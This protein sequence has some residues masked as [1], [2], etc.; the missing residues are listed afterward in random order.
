VASASCVIDDGGRP[1]SLGRFEDDVT[2]ILCGDQARSCCSMYGAGY[3]GGECGQLVT[4]L[5]E[6]IATGGATYNPSAAEACLAVLRDQVRR[7]NVDM[8]VFGFPD[9]SPVGTSPCGVFV[10]G[11]IPVGQACS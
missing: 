2:S 7:C 9:P 6:V 11:R 10:A 5:L 3:F 4:A 8:S 1:G